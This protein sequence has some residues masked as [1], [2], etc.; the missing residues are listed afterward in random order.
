MLMVLHRAPD[1]VTLQVRFC[2]GGATYQCMLMGFVPPK[3]KATVERSG[4]IVVVPWKPEFSLHVGVRYEANDEW[5]TQLQFGDEM[6]VVT[7]MLQQHVRQR[8]L[9][10]RD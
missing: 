4:N 7:T 10:K 2:A 5:V 8:T 3:A 6:E 1:P 9:P